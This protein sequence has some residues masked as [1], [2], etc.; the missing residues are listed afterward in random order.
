MNSEQR[1]REG[2]IKD[3][4]SFSANDRVLCV[5]T[6]VYLPSY[7]EWLTCLEMN[8]DVRKASGPAQMNPYAPVQLPVVRPKVLY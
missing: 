7:V 3:W 6:G 2:I 1:A 5:Q 4:T 8:R